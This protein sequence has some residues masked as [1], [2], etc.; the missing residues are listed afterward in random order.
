[1]QVLRVLRYAIVCAGSVLSVLACSGGD[2]NTQS[3][4]DGLRAPLAFFATPVEW[5]RDVTIESGIAADES[6]LRGGYGSSWADFDGDGWLDIWVVNHMYEPSLYLNNRDGTFMDMTASAWQPPTGDFHGAGWGD[7]DNDG[8][9]DL[10]QMAGGDGGASCFD[11]PFYVNESRTFVNQAAQRN[12]NDRCGRGRT[13]LWLDWNNDGR[14]DLHLVNGKRPQDDLSPS[15]LMIQQPN[16]TFA[17]LVEMQT[18]SNAF[19]ARLAWLDQALHMFTV[20]GDGFVALHQVGDATPR[21]VLLPDFANGKLPP[22]VNDIAIGDFDGDL[23]EDLFVVHTKPMGRSYRVVGEGRTLDVLV[24][25]LGVERGVS[26]SAP[27]VSA[28]RFRFYSTRWFTGDIRLGRAAVPAT[29]VRRAVNFY[30]ESITLDEVVVDPADP[31][32]AGV[33]G[34]ESRQQRGVYIGRAEDGRWL[35][36]AIGSKNDTLQFDLLVAPGP[37]S[38]VQSTGFEFRT[39]LAKKPTFLFFADGAFRSRGK[40][41]GMNFPLSCL[42]AVAG[43][44]DND[45]DLDL[46]MACTGPLSH[47]NNRLFENMGGY[48]VEVPDAGGG[49]V[50]D[51]EEPGGIVSAA[52]FDDDGNLD[53]FVSMGCTVCGPPLRFGRHVLLK[54]MRSGSHSIQFDLVGCQSNRDGIGARVVVSAGGKQQLRVA[55][56]GMHSSAQS[57][58]RVHFGLGPNVLAERVTVSWPSG[59]VTEVADLPADRIHTVRESLNCSRP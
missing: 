41:W 27:A 58:R 22:H 44:F 56:G 17:E 30:G 52:D 32:L 21:P 9:Q 19:M 38:D 11:K 35:V 48:F 34:P 51:L 36:Y 3:P 6:D 31:N 39:S 8:D 5:F 7:F 15:R 28:V 43:D 57:M 54:N 45:M 12:L 20:G 47:N 59:T 25:D 10:A 26:W 50:S 16:G 40:A 24:K 18:Q 55:D 37:V 13:P 4:G 14:L 29:V 33:P 42:S 2:E 1:M 46:F 49:S 23:Q 53:L